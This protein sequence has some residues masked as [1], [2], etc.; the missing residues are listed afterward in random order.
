[1]VPR[2]NRAH[3]P[4][5]GEARLPGRPRG[6]RG[7]DGGHQHRRRRPRRGRRGRRGGARVR[8][9]QLLHVRAGGAAPLP[10]LHSEAAR[11]QQEEQQEV[12]HL[13]DDGEADARDRHGGQ[14][15]ALRR[16]GRG[17]VRGQA[18][19]APKGP[20]KMSLIMTCRTN[21]INLQDLLHSSRILLR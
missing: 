6:R 5:Q 3:K 17:G 16:G 10:T 1:M 8:R 14:E 4:L 15:G 18:P 12:F 13:D 19:E 11:A 7:R 21:Y 2:L 9:R 20:S